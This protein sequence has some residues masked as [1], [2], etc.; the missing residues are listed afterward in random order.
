MNSPRTKLYRDKHH[1]KLLGVCAGIA[2]YTGINVTG[3]RVIA[4]ILT[5]AVWWT[6]PLYILAG[7]FLHKKPT[8]LYTDPA[9][10]KYW[11]NVRQSPQRT[12]R[13]IR[14]QMK[15]IDRRLAEVENFYVSG[16]LRDFLPKTY[17]SALRLVERSVRASHSSRPPALYPHSIH[18]AHR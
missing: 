13:E 12:A 8:H 9:E 7:I 5:L 15:D 2:D 10:D 3:V 1:G 4:V 14:A 6:L 17:A 18:I 11:Q 16:D